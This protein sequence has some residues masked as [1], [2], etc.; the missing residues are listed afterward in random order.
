V[1]S[2]TGA[3][4]FHSHTTPRLKA[5]QTLAAKNHYPQVAAPPFIAMEFVDGETLR[6]RLASQVMNLGMC[7]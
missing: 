6:Q 5:I 1:V 3:A 7:R 2:G 4:I